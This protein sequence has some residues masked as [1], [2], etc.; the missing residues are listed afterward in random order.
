MPSIVFVHGIGVR[1]GE[2]RSVWPHLQEGLRTV[3]PETPATFCYWGGELGARLDADSSPEVPE[4]LPEEIWAVSLTDPWWELT[5]LAERAAQQDSEP[6]PPHLAPAEPE[7]RRRLAALRTTPVPE[8][9]GLDR[10]LGSAVDEVLATDVV[11]DC[12]TRAD[13]LR[14][15]L[16]SALARALVALTVGR[17]GPD[18]PEVVPPGALDAFHAVLTTELGGRPMRVPDWVSRLA[19]RLITPHLEAGLRPI[20]W[21]MAVAR[22]PITRKVTPYLGDV[23]VYLARGEAIRDKV[24]ATIAGQPGPVDVIAH[25]LGGIACFD[26]LALGRLPRVRSLVTV[27][28]QIPYLYAIDALPGLRREAARPPLPTWLNVYDRHD[29]LSFPAEPHFAGAVTDHRL[30]SGLP[31]PLSHSAYFR[32]KKFYELLAGVIK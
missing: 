4:T 29:A 18:G 20:S 28:T 6:P 9:A 22:G 10:H 15:E 13:A 26:L 16:P 5:A 12:L 1:D 21:A 27:G 7:L 25:S 32:N 31:F 30:D 24:A 3:R 2:Y 11:T 23:M 14:D 17:S 8:A 19:L